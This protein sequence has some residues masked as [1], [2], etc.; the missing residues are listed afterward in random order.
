M[1]DSLDLLHRTYR[2]NP[3]LIEI[4]EWGLKNGYR[5]SP[6]AENGVLLSPLSKCHRPAMVSVLAKLVTV[7]NMADVKQVRSLERSAPDFFERLKAILDAT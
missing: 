7:R 5:V 4:I 2:E 6:A 3:V 1:G